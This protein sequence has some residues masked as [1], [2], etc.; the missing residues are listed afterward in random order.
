[1]HLPVI[2]C[3]YFA[4]YYQANKCEF[5]A[6]VLA[7]KVKALMSV[8]RIMH[9]TPTNSLHNERTQA[10][11]HSAYSSTSCI[12][13]NLSLLNTMSFMNLKKALIAKGIPREEIDNCP[14]KPTLLRLAAEHKFK[15]LLRT[16]V[17]SG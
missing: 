5:P 3:A 12:E 14:G 10:V 7:L 6:S 16:A 2:H 9:E 11:Q 15:S 17:D 1:M 4:D 8:N 13:I